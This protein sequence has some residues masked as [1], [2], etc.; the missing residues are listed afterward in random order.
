MN[1]AEVITLLR[2][3]KAHC[4]S[5]L[6]D[7]YTPEAWS[8][9]LDDISWVDANQALIKICK[10]DLEPGKSR[11]IEPG[12]IRGEVRRLRLKRLNDYG[13]I[14]TPR[15]PA[16]DGEDVWSP[17]IML[18][19][20]RYMRQMRELIAD[21]KLGAGETIPLVAMTQQEADE[22]AQ[23]KEALRAK[24]VPTWYQAEVEA[25]RM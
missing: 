23:Q 24:R 2:K 4:P 12:H 13:L 25:G 14:E 16:L 18:S 19:E 20:L 15:V 17:R 6:I 3:V 10:M 5:Q 11:Y 1:I 22:Q 7:E 8:E 9:V 21:G